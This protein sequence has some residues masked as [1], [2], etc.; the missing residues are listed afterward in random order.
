MYFSIIVVNLLA[1]IT[2]GPNMIAV[3]SESIFKGR[4]Y[5]ILTGLGLS[6]GAVLWVT[7]AV[8]GVE[9]LFELFPQFG[10]ILRIAGAGYLIWF[11]IKTLAAAI[12]GNGAFVVIE[13]TEQSNHKVFFHGFIVSITNP[14]AA[15]FFGSVLTAFVPPNAPTV[16]LLSI[17]ILCGILAVVCHTITATVFSSKAVIRH[18][19]HMQRGVTSLFGVVFTGIGIGV[20]YDTIRNR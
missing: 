10:F 7:L 3:I 8:V 16:I 18:F 17:I 13:N 1:W 19:N 6:A 5:G 12:G 9:T 4:R 14:K 2:P 20:V 15:F 11:G